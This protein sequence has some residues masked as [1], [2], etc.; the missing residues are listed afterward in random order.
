ME[1]TTN[2]ILVSLGLVVLGAIA[3]AVG[4]TSTSSPLYDKFSPDP[5]HSANT[6]W[7]GKK[8]TKYNY[9]WT[10]Y[11]G[12]ETVELGYV[13]IKTLDGTKT[14]HALRCWRKDLDKDAEAPFYFWVPE[15][16]LSGVLKKFADWGEVSESQTGDISITKPFT[17]FEEYPANFHHSRTSFLWATHITFNN[18]PQGCQIKYVSEGWEEHVK[19]NPNILFGQPVATSRQVQG[20]EKKMK[21]AKQE[22]FEFADPP[23]PFG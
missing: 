9:H 4:K 1:K 13:A 14:M 12:D 23:D 22:A 5:T 11:F 7:G 18:V 16:M 3:L 10:P 6:T 21:S 15:P 2:V 19:N 17:G 8:N 20:L